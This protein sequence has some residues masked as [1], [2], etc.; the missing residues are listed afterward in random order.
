LERGIE[1]KKKKGEEIVL[2]YIEKEK[3]I[4]SPIDHTRKKEVPLFY[5]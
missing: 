3:K 2:C 4:M 5:E 1:K